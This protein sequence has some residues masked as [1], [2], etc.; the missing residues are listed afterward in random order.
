MKKTKEKKQGLN[1]G[2]QAFCW[3]FG[4]VLCILFLEV[5]V[6]STDSLIGTIIAL[7]SVL[8]VGYQLGKIIQKWRITCCETIE[9]PD[10]CLA[11]GCST[12]EIKEVEASE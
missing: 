6:D 11:G 9:M 5:G 1:A 2:S 12:I 8:F 10:G 7:L 3:F 4:V